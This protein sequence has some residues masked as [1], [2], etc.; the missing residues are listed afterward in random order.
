MKNM[1]KLSDDKLALLLKRGRER[2]TCGQIAERL[3]LDPTYVSRLLRR[4][5]IEPYKGDGFSYRKWLADAYEK[6]RLSGKKTGRR[7]SFNGR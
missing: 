5:G 4:H 1:T 3:G 6:D 7:P 2:L